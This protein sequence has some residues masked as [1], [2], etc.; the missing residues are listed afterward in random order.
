MP[1]LSQ[2]GAGKQA[3]DLCLPHIWQL[4]NQEREA[5][6]LMGNTGCSLLEFS[7]RRSGGT[8]EQGSGGVAV[9]GSVQETWRCV[10][11]GYDMWAWTDMVLWNTN[12]ELENRSPLQAAHRAEEE[13]ASCIKIHEYKVQMNQCE[14]SGQVVTA[15]YKPKSLLCWILCSNFWFTHY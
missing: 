2:V 11:E 6:Q 9:P 3:S 4:N 13:L 8:L 1:N 15:H 10:T 5:L 14:L 12:T 7:L